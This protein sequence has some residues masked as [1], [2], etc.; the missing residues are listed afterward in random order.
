SSARVAVSR[1][2]ANHTSL[3]DEIVTSR[4]ARCLCP[5]GEAADAWKKQNRSEMQQRSDRNGAALNGAEASRH[6]E[7]ACVDCPSA[8]ASGQAHL[9]TLQCVAFERQLVG[10]E[11]GAAY[12]DTRVEARRLLRRERR[13]K[14]GHGT[15]EKSNGARRWSSG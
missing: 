1:L 12:D 3:S 15:G 5:T 11:P 2:M 4:V 6:A 10:L 9:S 13:P 14:Y 8:A 7:P